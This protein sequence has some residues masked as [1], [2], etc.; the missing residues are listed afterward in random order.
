MMAIDQNVFYIV[1]AVIVG[2][3]INSS[4]YAVEKGQR[5]TN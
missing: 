5:S 1:I 2:S 4:T 3:W